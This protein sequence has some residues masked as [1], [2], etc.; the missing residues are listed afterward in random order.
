MKRNRAFT[1]AKRKGFYVDVT[2]DSIISTP[3]DITKADATRWLDHAQIAV[4][5]V[6]GAVQQAR[7]NSPH[8]NPQ[9]S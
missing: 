2:G 6:S 9:E 4:A 8:G 5:M 3:F 7:L 1:I